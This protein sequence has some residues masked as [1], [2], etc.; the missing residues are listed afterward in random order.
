MA[1][2]IIAQEIGNKMAFNG[3]SPLCF[4]NILDKRSRLPNMNLDQGWLA[5]SF[6]E[7]KYSACDAGNVGT[8]IGLDELPKV[9]SS[10][11][12]FVCDMISNISH[13]SEV[14]TKVSDH[15]NR[16]VQGVKEMLHAISNLGAVVPAQLNRL[17]PVEGLHGANC[18]GCGFQRG[19]KKQR[20]GSVDVART[21]TE[22]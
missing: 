16:M 10:A 19:Q 4:E 9:G 22:L 18:R 2:L 6:R 17:C 12:V 14:S 20:V 8:V 21:T 15:G 11:F 3:F 5:D 13:L 7:K 1:F